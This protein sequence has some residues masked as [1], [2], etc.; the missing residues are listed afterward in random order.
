MS[1][2]ELISFVK[3]VAEVQRQDGRARYGNCVYRVLIAHYPRIWK[4]VVRNA[5]EL[6]NIHA[7]DDPMMEEL[8]SFLNTFS[9]RKG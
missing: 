6:H 7:P 8:L 2:F 4:S 9:G 1:R 3:Q 5:F